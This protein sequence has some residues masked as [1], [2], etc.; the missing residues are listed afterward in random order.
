MKKANEFLNKYSFVKYV[1]AALVAVIA[2]LAVYGTGYLNPT[3]DKWIMSGY[4]E[5]DIIS[6]YSGWLAYRN[7]DWG[8]PVGIAADMA[9]PEG[10]Y[11]SF[12]DSIP[13]VA[14]FFKL[15]RGILPETFQYFGLYLLGS[16]ILQGIA[17]YKLIEYKTKN[18]VYSILG[19]VLFLF[20]PV[21]LD[22]SLRH[23]ALS[24]QWFILFSIL[25]WQ[26][27]KEKYR[28]RDYIFYMILL[29]LAIG[30]HPYFLPMIGMFMFL[31]LIDDLAQKKFLTIAYFFGNLIITYLAGRFIG[32]LGTGVGASRGGYGYFSMNLNAL[33]NPTSIGGYRWSAIIP[34]SPQMPGSYDGFTYAGAGILLGFIAV[35]VLVVIKG[36]IKKVPRVLKNN[37][38]VI[39]V[40]VFCTLFAITNIVTF[41]DK[42]LFTIKLPKVI[43]ETCGIFR[44]SARMF[45][46]VFYLACFAII[47]TLW[48][49]R[50]MGK[51]RAVFYIL[52]FLC[53]LQIFDLHFALAEKHRRMKNGIVFESIL[54]D[55]ALNDIFKNSESLLLDNYNIR[56]DYAI[57]VVPLKHHNKLYYSSAGSGTFDKVIAES[58]RIRSY[59]K[60]T[61]DIGKNVIVTDIPEDINQYTC[62]ENIGYYELNGL[63]YI[64]DTSLSDYV[65]K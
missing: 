56:V 19:E 29:V 45:Y 62:H 60:E 31:S 2:F 40:S 37:I 43:E 41:N 65:T 58:E 53:A 20:V 25:I 12:T 3:N 23:T 61:G 35:L 18:F 9:V 57:S 54:D 38:P 21:F 34:V 24:S 32:V 13:W 17:G 15:I 27:H 28:I 5:T 63:Y 49:Y 50:E 8:F 33:W 10:M 22:R 42:T 46:P 36:D 48:K 1:I 26:M 11:I 30:I 16:Y 44:A 51:K 39:A 4:D 52:L 64:A 59:I 55:W 6:H 47:I 7:S 14:I